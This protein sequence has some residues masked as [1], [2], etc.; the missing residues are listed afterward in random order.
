[1]GFSSQVDFCSST[2]AE[3][4]PREDCESR[5][6]MPSLP[7]TSGVPSQHPET[8]EKPVKDEVECSQA[9]PDASSQCPQG[10]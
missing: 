3:A 6:P 2:P 10:A 8:L 7:P 9:W 1:M 5:L 4:G